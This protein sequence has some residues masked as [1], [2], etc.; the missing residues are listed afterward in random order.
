MCENHC[1]INLKDVGITRFTQVCTG[2][3]TMGFDKIS[4]VS[5]TDLFV[6]QIENMILSGELSVGASAN[7]LSKNIL[8]LI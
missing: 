8:L 5:L 2:G 4:A 3:L 6:Q 7:L 1:K